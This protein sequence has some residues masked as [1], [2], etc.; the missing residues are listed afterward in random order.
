VSATIPGLCSAGTEP[1][2]SHVLG[3]CS[4][5]AEL[6]PLVLELMVCQANISVK[7]IQCVKGGFLRTLL[8]ATVKSDTEFVHV[9]G[10]FRR[11]RRR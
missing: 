10:L 11:Y 8:V 2:A 9:G 5:P 1:R 3:N 7:G 6:R 4:L